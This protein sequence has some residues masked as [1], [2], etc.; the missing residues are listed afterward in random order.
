MQKEV[1][2]VQIQEAECTKAWRFE[3]DHTTGPMCLVERKHQVQGKAAG[4]REEGF[5]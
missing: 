2:A 4:V 3:K 5:G 1:R